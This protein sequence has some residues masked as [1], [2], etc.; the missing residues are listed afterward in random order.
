MKPFQSITTVCVT[1]PGGQKLDAVA[2]E[3]EKPVSA[4]E[5]STGSY[6]V[7]GRTVVGVFPAASTDPADRS[8][9]GRYVIVKLSPEDEAADLMYFDKPG[10][11][12]RFVRRDPVVSIRQ[13][14]AVGGLPAWDAPA[15]ATA[16]RELIVEK[17]TEHVFAGEKYARP[18]PYNL[19]LPEG[20]D[21]NGSYPLVMFIHDLGPLCENV[22]NTLRQG[23]G[24]TVW[25]TP[26][27][28]D[29]HKCIVLAPQYQAPPFRDPSEHMVEATF[30]LVDYICENYAVDKK[31]VYATGQSMGTITEIR[32]SIERPDFF[33]ALMLVAGQ[34]EPEPMLAM[35]DVKMFIIVSRGDPRAYDGMN[36][37]L[38][39]MSEAG[40]KVIRADWD[41][42]GGVVP[43]EQVAELREREGDI[44]YAVL[45]TEKRDFSC[46][47]DTW[48]VAYGIEGVRDWLF[49]QSK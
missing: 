15:G 36:A 30:D 5:L 38:A 31:R 41:Q 1:Y 26:E 12:G 6:A 16:D 47:M 7:E 27:V 18:L 42:D 37:S 35:K 34:Y 8:D 2:V 33:T 3:Y 49:E 48:K 13:V 44:R 19:Y 28:Q 4:G 39:L 11:D 46:H 29:K 45:K 22:R 14:R 21:P 24:A 17:F 25:A 43:E 10:R 40:K 9:M 23:V 20:Y 32:M